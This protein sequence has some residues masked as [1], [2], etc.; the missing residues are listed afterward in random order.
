MWNQKNYTGDF[1]ENDPYVRFTKG[2]PPDSSADWGWVQH[3]AASL[4]DQG[5]AAIV[6]DTGAVSRGSGSKSNN[7]EKTIRQAFVEA[8]WIE[9][10]ILLP[11]NLFYNTTAPGI[12]LLLNKAKPATRRGQ[13]L[14]VNASNF[15]VKEKPKNAL[16]DEGVAAVVEVYRKWETREKLSRVI[17]LAEAREADYNLSPSLFVEVNGQA[18]HRSLAQILSDLD[19]ARIRRE[20]AD[21][22][23]ANM[24]ARMGL[25]FGKQQ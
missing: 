13:I 11:E 15:F 22:S 9:G 4:D 18:Q 3:M 21:I 6:L 2:A 5:R 25:S 1:Y 7:K 8:D 19:D 20:Q 23:L 24:L 17:T 14:L 16:T 10:V 12:I